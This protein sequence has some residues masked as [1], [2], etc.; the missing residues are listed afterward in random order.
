MSCNGWDGWEGWVNWDSWDSRNNLDQFVN[1]NNK[2]KITRH[3][4]KCSLQL[5]H[6]QSKVV[7]F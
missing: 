1:N 2:N 3:P 7:N 5:R 6:L 4:A